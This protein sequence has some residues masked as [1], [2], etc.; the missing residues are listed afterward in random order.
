METLEEGA[1]LEADRQTVWW[2]GQTAWEGS[3]EDIAVPTV[4]DAEAAVATED[5]LLL[6]ARSR[7]WRPVPGLSS[8]PRSPRVRDH[9]GRCG[10]RGMVA[11]T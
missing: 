9:C 8:C 5:A 2:A 10:R 11:T 7:T 4:V 1:V 3:L 6:K